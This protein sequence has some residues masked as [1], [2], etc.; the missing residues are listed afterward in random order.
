MYLKD[1][2]CW[3]TVGVAFCACNN[4][5]FG[6][7]ADNSGGTFGSVWRAPWIQTRVPHKYAIKSRRRPALFDRICCWRHSLIRQ[8]DANGPRAVTLSRAHTQK[9]LQG[10]QHQH[11]AAFNETKILHACSYILA[12]VVTNTCH[13][14]QLVTCKWF[15]QKS[16]V[17]SRG[18]SLYSW[19][20]EQ[21]CMPGT[22]TSRTQMN[23][24]SHV[25]ASRDKRQNS[26]R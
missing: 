23:H 24:C 13:A 15:L 11:Q 22:A 16:T 21:L 19:P 3:L 14:S 2:L 4:A 8:P 17:L 5:N 26:Q 7:V 10:G 9:S 20:G 18:F 12:T 25:A 6:M 1:S